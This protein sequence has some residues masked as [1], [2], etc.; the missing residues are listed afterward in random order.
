MIVKQQ[1]RHGDAA[2]GGA[3]GVATA[4][5]AAA[6]QLV[7]GV[8]EG[9]RS[10]LGDEHATVDAEGLVSGVG[11][12]GLPCG[13]GGGPAAAVAAQRGRHRAQIVRSGRRCGI[14]GNGRE[15]QPN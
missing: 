9:W 11:R 4:G 10:E 6:R 2:D 14:H 7:E 1:I 3:M 12:A 13:V 8:G 5:A 15:C